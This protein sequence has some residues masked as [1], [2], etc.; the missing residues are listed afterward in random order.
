M[1]ERMIQA[2][3]QKDHIDQTWCEVPYFKG[4]LY[5]FGGSQVPEETNEEGSPGKI[6]Y[7]GKLIKPG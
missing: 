2:C 4:F 3:Q 5:R 1:P 6:D 7:H